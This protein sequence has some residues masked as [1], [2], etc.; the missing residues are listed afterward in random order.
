VFVVCL[1]ETKLRDPSKRILKELRAFRLME[2]RVLNMIGTSGDE[3]DVTT[4]WR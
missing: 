1:E 4:K 3:L 2:W